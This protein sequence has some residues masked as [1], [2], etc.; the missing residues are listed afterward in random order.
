M[1]PHDVAL[2]A[3]YARRAGDFGECYESDS[4]VA[5]NVRISVGAVR[6]SKAKLKARGYVLV[7]E[8]PGSVS[9]IRIAERS[10]ATAAHGSQ[11]E[12]SLGPV[13][14]ANRSPPRQRYG[15]HPDRS[16]N[17]DR[18]QDGGRTDLSA[19]LAKVDPVKQ[20]PRNRSREAAR[21]GARDTLLRRARGGEL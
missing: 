14:V 9:R 20:I 21:A 3:W 15:D 16:P 11:G 12:L 17:P 19:R 18:S 4:K 1:T 10:G 13:G 8:H 5:A 7:K 6:R 2:Y